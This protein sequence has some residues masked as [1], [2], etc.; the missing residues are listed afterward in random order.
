MV[1]GTR[2]P[3]ALCVVHIV[4]LTGAIILAVMP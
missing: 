4:Q 3:H 2:S 1:A